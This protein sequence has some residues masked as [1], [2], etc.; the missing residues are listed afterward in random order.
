[1]DRL[2][3]NTTKVFGNW[4]RVKTPDHNLPFTIVDQSAIKTYM[5]ACIISS[6]N[7][8]VCIIQLLITYLCWYRRF[9]MLCSFEDNRCIR[10]KI[11]LWCKLAYPYFSEK[12]FYKQVITGSCST[13]EIERCTMYTSLFTELASVKTKRNH[14]LGLN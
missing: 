1:M 3:S 8:T 11:L 2:D 13:F 12:Q 4:N 6:G 10:N 5:K 9:E 7:S 14:G